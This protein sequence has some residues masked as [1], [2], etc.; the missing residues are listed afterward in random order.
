MPKTAGTAEHSCTIFSYKEATERLPFAWNPHPLQ[1]RGIVHLRLANVTKCLAGED[2]N[3]PSH[4]L[5]PL[6][7]CPIPAAVTLK[8]SSVNALQ[9]IEDC[10][11]QLKG[12]QKLQQSWLEACAKKQKEAAPVENMM[13]G[14]KRKAAPS[15]AS[16]ME[17]LCSLD[18]LNKFQFL[19]PLHVSISSDTQLSPVNV[20]NVEHKDKS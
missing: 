7:S 13:Q 6:L 20:S 17:D 4:G 3:N 10:E 16:A 14:Y 2:D 15:F 8:P 11:R 9:S 19:F 18:W 1:D 5:P 12:K